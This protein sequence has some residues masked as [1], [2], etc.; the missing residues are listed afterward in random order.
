LECIIIM[1]FKIYPLDSQLSHRS[2]HPPVPPVLRRDLELVDKGVRV[3]LP[4]VPDDALSPLKPRRLIALHI[5]EQETVGL[6]YLHDARPE[7]VRE[8]R[9]EDACAQTCFTRIGLNRRMH[10]HGRVLHALG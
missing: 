4:Q 10:A 6:L 1:M 9:Q 3:A 5:P 7:S 2:T 8:M